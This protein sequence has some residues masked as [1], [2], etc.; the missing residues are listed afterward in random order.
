[1]KPKTG[2][3]RDKARLF[4]FFFCSVFK[5]NVYVLNAR[6][7][8]PMHLHYIC[9]PQITC[10]V[11]RNLKQWSKYLSFYLYTYP[12][13]PKN[14]TK[15]NL[16][17]V[18]RKHILYSVGYCCYIVVAIDMVEE[19]NHSCSIM[20]IQF[21]INSH[22]IW[23][24]FLRSDGFQLI[25]KRRCC[26]I[27]VRTSCDITLHIHFVLVILMFSGQAVVISKILEI[28]RIVTTLA[29]HIL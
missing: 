27:T 26:A 23:S 18:H 4:F 13:C 12:Y 16:H 10:W 11:D 5:C 6:W 17:K 15:N 21:A 3:K 22:P 29:D 2:A 14:M 1:M 9:S 20:H 24:H 8:F 19:D 7:L 25:L 28:G